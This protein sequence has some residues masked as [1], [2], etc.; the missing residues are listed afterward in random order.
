[1]GDTYKHSSHALVFNDINTSN[2]H[3]TTGGTIIGSFDP[4]YIAV[5]PVGLTKKHYIEN[6]TSLDY[7][8]EFQNTGTDTAFNIKIFDELDE[9]LS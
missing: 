1:M 5:D 2:N 6:G 7:Y 8:I 4:N 9:D 3:D